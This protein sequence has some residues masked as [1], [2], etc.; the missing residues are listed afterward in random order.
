MTWKV[1]IVALCAFSYAGN[2]QHAL[3][4]S[5]PRIS[6]HRGASLAAPENTL[7]SYRK[8]IEQGADFIEVDVRTTA[9]GKQVCLHDASLKRT[10][11]LD[12][13]VD[14]VSLGEIRQLSAGRFFSA[15]Y[16]AEKIPTFEEVCQLVGSIRSKRQRHVSLYVDCKAISTDEVIR[17]LRHYKL[18][19]DA[20][21]YGDV[22]T[23]RQIRSKA[24]EARLLPAYDPDTY[25]RVADELH[26]YGFDVAWEL[27]SQRV[28]SQCHEKGI[29]VFCDILDE[30]D[31]V[32]SYE[33]AIELGVDVIQT[34]NVKE[35][36][37]L[38]NGI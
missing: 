2:A 7:A 17:L 28:I 12:S 27:L 6:A 8:A 20:V 14:Q 3:Q 29:L 19:G 32:S 34:D 38:V 16:A 36:K 24:P 1:F 22:P 26:P 25:E 21:F 35:V 30:N 15:V 33:K 23:L 13:G 18:L 5:R 10:T 9:D 4:Q 11:G 31:R 37:E